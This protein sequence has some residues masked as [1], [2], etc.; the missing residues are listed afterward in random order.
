MEIG[1]SSA[2]LYPKV[3]IEESIQV[4]KKLKFNIGEI[5][6]NTYS[7]YDEDFIKKLQEQ[8]EKNQFIINSIHAYSSMFEPYL[9]DTYRRRQRDMLKIFRKVCR[10]GR[11][12]NAKYYT[13]HGMR[14]S[15]ILDLNMNYIVDVYDELNYIASEEQIKLAQENVAWCMSSSLD[16]LNMLNEKCN[17]QLNYTLDIKQ[18]FKIGKDPMEYINTMGNKIVNVHINDKN[19]RNICLLPGK[20]NVNLKKICCKLKG[21]GYNNVYTIEVYNDNYSS[22]SEITDSKDFLENIL[23]S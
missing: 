19:E 10:A 9:F 5:F 12:L 21:I 13:F 3:P 1:M 7:E 22:L 17:R 8:K 11:L 18:A 15:N 6:L 20:G 2:C 23:L 14:R 16:F 4:M